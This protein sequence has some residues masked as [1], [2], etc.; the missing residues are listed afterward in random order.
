MPLVQAVKYPKFTLSQHTFSSKVLDGNYGGKKPFYLIITYIP[1]KT[2]E[3][4]ALEITLC[5]KYHHIFTS[6]ATYDYI[7]P[8]ATK[9]F[10]CTYLFFSLRHELGMS[11]ICFPQNP[12]VLYSQRLKVYFLNVGVLIKFR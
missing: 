11:N 2:F 3:K 12:A 9:F 7:L 10:L 5:G 6:S 1:N 4:Y 8:N